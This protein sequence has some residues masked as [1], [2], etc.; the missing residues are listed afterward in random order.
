MTDDQSPAWSF[1]QFVQVAVSS[2]EFQEWLTKVNENDVT[3]N[4][5]L[6]DNRKG[7]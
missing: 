4:K 5:L 1:D 2:R 7:E 3:L 6:N